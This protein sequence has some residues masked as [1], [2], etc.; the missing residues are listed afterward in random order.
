MTELVLSAEDAKTI[1]A[2]LLGGPTERCAVLFAEQT[3]RADGTERLLVR[4]FQFP[5]ES[6]YSRQ[7]ALEAVGSGNSADCF[8]ET[9]RTPAAS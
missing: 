9:L 8:P 4:E 5:D 1:L 6:D 2:E 7:G 3:L